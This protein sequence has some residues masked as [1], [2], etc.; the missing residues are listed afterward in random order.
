MKN[1][2]NLLGRTAR[3]IAVVSSMAVPLVFAGC[4]EENYIP[5]A[6]L[7]VSPI[8]GEAPLSVRM[9]VTGT[10]ANGNDDIKQYKLNINK[11]V[12]NSNTPIDITRTLDTPGI[13]NIYGEV[14]DS[15]NASDKTE[16][17]SVEVKGRPFIEQYAS[18]INDVDII[19]SATLSYVDK[20]Q[21]EVKR[22]GVLLSTEEVKDVNPSGPDYN[23]T[24]N[25]TIDGI[26]KGNYEFVLT[27]GNLEDKDNVVIP[28]YFPTINMS[29]TK[30]DLDEEADSTITLPKP[31][32]KNPEDKDK[33]A[34][35]YAKPL[36]VKTKVA[37]N[38]YELSITA[39]PGQTG[40][41]QVEF[42]YGS[43]SGGLEKKIIGG[44]IIKDMRIKVNPFISLDENG[45]EYN[46]LEIRADMDNFILA[47]LGLNNGD[48]IS[49][50][51]NPPY[52]CVN[53]SIQLVVDSKNLGE[54][55]HTIS[56]DFGKYWLYNNYMGN[57]LDS[58]YKNGGTLN[59]MGTMGV[60]IMIASLSDT[61]HYS[62]YF[63][64]SMNCTV[65]GNDLKKWED[66]N[67]IEPSTDQ[68]K[69]QPG[70]GK[71]PRNC[72]EVIIT[73][74]Y[75]VEDKINGNYLKSINLVKFRIEDGILSL[76]W[77]NKDPNLNIIKQRGK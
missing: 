72:D 69:L 53:Y 76:I 18:L 58:I 71:I 36:D 27:A 21:L 42:E 52:N 22:E 20:A 24:F 41:Y 73:Y 40:P 25:Y 74:P 7:E 66:W 68:T 50:S 5:D 60:P 64:H 57:N 70:Q 39:L 67:F 17:S 19:Y 54:R 15:E 49:P 45:A 28:E 77:E 35:Q 55:I 65:T 59:K 12:I 31:D 29:N 34:I 51:I 26:T 23:K 38:G 75:L 3:N 43:V 32:D 44:E 14:V 2:A 37:L 61:S 30:I 16:I 47:R 56:S 10:D 11:E 6:K 9:K 4:R 8:Y 13:Y 48:K 46:A 1:L 62:S 63:E 33:V